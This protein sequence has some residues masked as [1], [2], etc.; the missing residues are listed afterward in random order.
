MVFYQEIVGVL[1]EFI[2]VIEEVV[3]CVLEVILLEL[4]SDIYCIGLYLM[5]GGVLLCGF[6]KWIVFKMKLLVYIVDDLLCVVVC[7]MSVV[8][9]DIDCYMLIFILRGSV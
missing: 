5:G 9:V 8:L 4:V 7:G 3:L 6:D 1:D 2:I